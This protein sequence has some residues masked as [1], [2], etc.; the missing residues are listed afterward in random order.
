MDEVA[1]S[2][3]LAGKKSSQKQ[4]APAENESAGAED[5]EETSC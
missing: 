2:F 4:K 1:G 5:L 3:A